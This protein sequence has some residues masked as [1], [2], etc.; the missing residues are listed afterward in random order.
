MLKLTTLALLALVC[1]CHAQG[2]PGD[3]ASPEPVRPAGVDQPGAGA[4]APG[5]LAF[6]SPEAAVTAQ[7]GAP[8]AR[9]EETGFQWRRYTVGTTE[10]SLGFYRDQLGQVRLKPAA[11]WSWPEAAAWARA[12]LPAFDDARLDKSDPAVWRYLQAITVNR[13]PF[14]AGLNFTQ[15]GGLTVA[16]DGEMNWLD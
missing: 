1:A 4:P 16:I 14:E 15:Q 12:F 10:V 6:G 9:W 13:L 2:T 3:P 11:A 5:A 7:L 8:T